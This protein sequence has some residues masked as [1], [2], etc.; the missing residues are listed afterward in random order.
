MMAAAQRRVLLM[1]HTKLGQGALHR[2]GSVTD[3]THVVVDQKADLSLMSTIAEA[4]VEVI[5]APSSNG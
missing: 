4:G 5:V 1:D 3:F 2:L